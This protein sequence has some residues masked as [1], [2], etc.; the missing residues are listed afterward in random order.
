[1]AK[2][3][4]ETSY[5]VIHA[6]SYRGTWYTRENEDE[7]AEIL[8]IEDAKR[9]VGLGYIEDVSDE[10]EVQAEITEPEKEE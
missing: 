8:T 1:M 7:V 10:K 3:K 9:K 6:F 2:T 4:A 5:R